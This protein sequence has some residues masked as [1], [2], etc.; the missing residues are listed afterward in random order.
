MRRKHAPT[1]ETLLSE[2][3]FEKRMKEWKA[4]ITFVVDWRT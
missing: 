1:I 2:K 3:Q 4:K